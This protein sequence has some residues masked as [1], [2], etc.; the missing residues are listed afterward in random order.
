MP[1]PLHPRRRLLYAG[2]V[3]LASAV[4]GWILLP[5]APEQGPPPP[6]A[7]TPPEGVVARRFQQAS[8][9]GGETKWRLEAVTAEHRP[10]ENQTL[11]TELALTFYTDEGREVRLTAPEGRIEPGGERLVARRG[12]VVR[13]GEYRLYTES[14]HHERRAGTLVAPEAVRLVGPALVL[15]ADTLEVRPREGAA[16]F[17]G[18]VR[19]R[20]ASG[21]SVDFSRENH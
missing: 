6:A 11:L 1:F 5:G 21:G 10:A 15:T 19:L 4:A 8:S 20:V 16:D 3:L 12:V 17:R 7:P 2:A 14:L 9:R 13:E 18:R